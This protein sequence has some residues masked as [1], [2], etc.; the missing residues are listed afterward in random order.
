MLLG[1]VLSLVLNSF[2]V[3]AEPGKTKY[4]SGECDSCRTVVEQFYKGWEK[5]VHGLAADGTYESRSGAA[6]KITYNQDIEDYLQGFCDSEYMKGY[7]EYIGDGCKTF[8]KNHHRPMVGKFLHGEEKFSSSLSKTQK[9]AR[10]RSVCTELGKVCPAW[11][12]AELE[13]KSKQDACNACQGVVM[14]A[15]FLL[16]RSTFGELSASALKKKKLEIFDMLENLCLDTY[17]RHDDEPTARHDVCAHMW[18]E[19]EDEMIDTMIKHFKDTTAAVQAMCVDK[20]EFCKPSSPISV[21]K[22]HNEL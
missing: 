6:P 18:E 4:T 15:A 11:P 20:F 2:S 1:A 9:P 8:M 14:D 17:T 22:A 10:I 7:A 3:A 21:S 19:D 5:V 12:P 13:V 16:R